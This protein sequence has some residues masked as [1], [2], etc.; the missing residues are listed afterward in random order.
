MSVGLRNLPGL[1]LALSLIAPATAEGRRAAIESVIEAFSRND[2]DAAF[3]FA[4]PEI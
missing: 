1:F 4:S 3:A 2:G